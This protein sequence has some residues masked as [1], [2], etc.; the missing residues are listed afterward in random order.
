VL[1]DVQPR[2]RLERSTSFKLA[3][4]DRGELP[5][6]PATANFVTAMQPFAAVAPKTA[7]LDSTACCSL[8][9]ALDGA[10]HGAA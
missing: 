6:S 10:C 9:R 2:P 8:Q 1:L 3:G 4:I 7:V 5:V